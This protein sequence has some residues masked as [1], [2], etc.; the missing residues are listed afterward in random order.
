MYLSAYI[1]T[2]VQQPLFLTTHSTTGYLV[3]QSWSC[4]A[5]V[6]SWCMCVF[7]VLSILLAQCLVA[8]LSSSPCCPTSVVLSL[9]PA[10]QEWTCTKTVD[11]NPDPQGSSDRP[12]W[13]TVHYDAI[14]RPQVA[15]QMEFQWV[16]TTA[17]V[18]AKQASPFYRNYTK[19]QRLCRPCHAMLY[20]YLIG[21]WLKDKS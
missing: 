9:P 3:S 16:V 5:C 4:S 11:L 21:N 20:T 18:L 15:F 10:D 14:F 1:R 2:Y 7:T 6:R 17:T 19:L 13:T 8:L 12:E